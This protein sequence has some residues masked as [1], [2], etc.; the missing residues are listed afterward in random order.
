MES[1]SEVRDKNKQNAVGTES[2]PEKIIW[3]V[4]N[5]V[6]YRRGFAGELRVLTFRFNIPETYIRL[7]TCTYKCQDG[8]P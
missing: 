5:Y 7:S 4:S 8:G 3:S 2:E 1:S 6:V